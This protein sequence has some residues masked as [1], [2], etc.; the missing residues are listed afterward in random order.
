MAT[1]DA[2][3]TEMSSRE[4]LI[5][6]LPDVAALFEADARDFSNDWAIIMRELETMYNNNEFYM[7][8]IER[9][10]MSVYSV[11]R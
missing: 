8:D 4:T 11:I 5:P 2:I 6:E 9:F 3:T 1:N 7:Q 10:S